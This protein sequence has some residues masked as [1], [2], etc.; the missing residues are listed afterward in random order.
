MKI[1]YSLYIFKK[2]WKEI[3]KNKEILLPVIF[4]PLLFSIIVPILILGTTIYIPLDQLDDVSELINIIPFFQ[5]QE[6][7]ELKTMIYFYVNFLMKPLFLLSPIIT[8]IVIASDS[9]AGEKERKTI[10][11]LLILPISDK[12]LILGKVFTSLIPGIVAT[13]GAFGVFQII[14]FIMTYEIFG[15]FLIGLDWFLLVLLFGTLLS[16]LSVLLITINSSRAKNAKS[17]QNVAVLF[18]L[19]LISLIFLQF[20]NIF[21]LNV[22]NILLLSGFLA[23]LDIIMIYLGEKQLNRDHLISQI[24]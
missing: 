24:R 10:E 22:I 5:G 13:W 9:F 16:L 3:Y 1:R 2:D 6:N 19:P 4:I 15:F 20:T 7:A 8:T 21:I 23:V 14:I 17:A 18:I 11:S 12:E